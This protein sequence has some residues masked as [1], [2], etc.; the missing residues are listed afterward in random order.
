ML[1]TFLGRA[2]CLRTLTPSLPYAKHSG[3]QAILL[4]ISTS[5]L[6]RHHCAPPS[7]YTFKLYRDLAP[8][9]CFQ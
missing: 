2:T 7:P 8:T 5:T 6:T 3:A 1:P 4:G 9:A